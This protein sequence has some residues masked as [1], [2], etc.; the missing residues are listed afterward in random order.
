MVL[1]DLVGALGT[2]LEKLLNG[3]LMAFVHIITLIFY[4]LFDI[5]S[6]LYGNIT[7]PDF[8]QYSIYITRFWDL[9]FQ[10]VGYIRSIFLI[11]SLSMQ[12]IFISLII[13]L[14]YKPAI[15]LVKMFVHWVANLK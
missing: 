12:L 9:C 14:T 2:F 1:E 8:S 7:V 11:D 13:K 5:L 10:F 15:A 3:L 6:L 4:W